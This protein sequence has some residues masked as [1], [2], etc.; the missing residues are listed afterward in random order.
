MWA[1][2]PLNL[3]TRVFLVGRQC[4]LNAARTMSRSVYVSK[5]L[6][7]AG[8]RKT[9]IRELARYSSPAA[10]RQSSVPSDRLAQEET[11]N[12]RSNCVLAL[13]LEASFLNVLSPGSL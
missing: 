10:A 3:S 6:Q 7:V 8:R 1:H 2:C 11:V 13:D 9:T 4:G 12:E 5:P